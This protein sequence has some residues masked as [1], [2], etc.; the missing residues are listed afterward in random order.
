[1]D[2]TF[3]QLSLDANQLVTNC[4]N[5]SCYLE[6]S[7]ITDKIFFPSNFKVKS[8]TQH[9]EDFFL[10]HTRYFCLDDCSAYL[11]EVIKN[12]AEFSKLLNPSW[13]I[14]IAVQVDWQRRLVDDCL[15]ARH[16]E[17]V[18]AVV[19]PGIDQSFFAEAEDLPARQGTCAKEVHTDFKFLGTCICIYMSC[20]RTV[21]HLHGPHSLQ[22]CYPCKSA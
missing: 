15:H 4:I 3:Q 10:S 16:S 8:M 19:K 9:K 6:A 17:V 13:H 22:P 11:V 18:V 20:T 12:N 5:N 7:F 2:I 21:M 1:M 14:N